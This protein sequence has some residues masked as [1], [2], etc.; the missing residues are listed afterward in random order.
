MEGVQDIYELSPMQHGML[1]DSVTSGNSGMYLMQLE[2]FLAGP[3]DVEALREAWQRTFDRHAI[4]RTSIHWDELA[5][6]LQVVHEELEVALPVE[7]ISTLD[8]DAQ[9][10]CIAA[11]RD[12]DRARGVAFDEAPLTRLALFRTGP[13]SWRLVWSM[14]HILMEGWSASIV[15]GEVLQHYRGLTDGTSPELAE[16]RPYRDYITWIQEQDPKAAENWWRS[17]LAG[18]EVPTHLGIDGSP[19]RMHT[20]VTEFDGR[21]IR[22]SADDSTGLT[23]FAQRHGITLNTLVQGAWAV[24]LS[25]YSG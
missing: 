6:P 4:L 21:Q 24:L 23:A 25:R 3:L 8:S 5:K 15:L 9:T 18:F 22:L 10:E 17:E 12:E 16:H 11:F 2:Y 1:Y 20:P 19:T 13:G 14:H 7:D